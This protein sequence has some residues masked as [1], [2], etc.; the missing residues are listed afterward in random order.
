MIE[1]IPNTEFE[2]CVLDFPDR[3]TL[4]LRCFTE[5]VEVVRD[6]AIYAE[7]FDL[8]DPRC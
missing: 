1:I 3:F 2:I 8:A 7:R 5:V 6:Q 4:V